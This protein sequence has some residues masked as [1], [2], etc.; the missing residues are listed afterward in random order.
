M[1]DDGAGGG[2]NTSLYQA[3]HSDGDMLSQSSTNGRRSKVNEKSYASAA[4][5][6]LLSW[7]QTASRK[8]LAMLGKDKELADFFE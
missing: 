6:H 2:C 3:G 7:S 1:N 4:P 5:I 8:E